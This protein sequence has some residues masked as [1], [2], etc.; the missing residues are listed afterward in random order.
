MNSLDYLDLV[1]RDATLVN[2]I[3]GALYAMQVTNGTPIL[4][5]RAKSVIEFEYEIEE[6][7]QAHKLLICDDEDRMPPLRRRRL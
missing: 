3:F 7:K 5:S 1:N 6:L 2:A 4:R